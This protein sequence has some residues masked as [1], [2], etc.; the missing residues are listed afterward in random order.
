MPRVKDTF[1]KSGYRIT[2]KSLLRYLDSRLFSPISV[3]GTFITEIGLSDHLQWSVMKIFV[4]WTILLSMTVRRSQRGGIQPCC[5]RNLQMF[6]SASDGTS[7][8]PWKNDSPTNRRSKER[9]TVKKTSTDKTS[10]ETKGRKKNVER[11]KSKGHNIEWKITTIGQKVESTKC[12]MGHNIEWEVKTNG[13]NVK[14][15]KRRIEHNRLRRFVGEPFILVS[16]VH[17]W[18]ARRCRRWWRWWWPRPPLS[19]SWTPPWTGSL[20]GPGI[21]SRLSLP[22]RTNTVCFCLVADLGTMNIFI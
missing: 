11:V 4:T 19:S 6:K 1:N 5:T 17:T 3:V 7:P 21:C 9:P 2:V 16:Y 14:S 22:A 8:P 13:N 20:S 15:S 18:S 10:N 12:R